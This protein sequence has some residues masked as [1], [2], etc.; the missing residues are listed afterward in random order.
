MHEVKPGAGIGFRNIGIH[1]VSDRY[2]NDYI[3]KP[4]LLQLRPNDCGSDSSLDLR[5]DESLYQRLTKMTTV[6]VDMG[7]NG[8]FTADEFRT[9]SAPGS[10]EMISPQEI[11]E[12]CVQELLGIGT[13]KNVLSSIRGAVLQPGYRA[14]FL[15]VRKKKI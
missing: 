3:R 9:L 12:V 11:S 5:E 4:H 13:G 2:G 15:R 6:A 1:P 7:E 8:L 14:G 10:M